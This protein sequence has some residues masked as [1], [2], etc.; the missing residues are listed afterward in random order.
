MDQLSQVSFHILTH[1]FERNIA[2]SMLV[3]LVCIYIKFAL[4][5]CEYR[6]IRYT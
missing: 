1:S 5:V 6:K 3:E 2:S 4:Q